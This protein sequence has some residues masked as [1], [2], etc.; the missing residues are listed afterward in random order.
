M[1]PREKALASHSLTCGSATFSL[2]PPAYC[3]LANY[4]ITSQKWVFGDPSS[5]S[6]DTSYVTG[7]THVYNK[8]GSFVVKL[9]T[10]YPCFV[11]TTLETVI[12]SGLPQVTITGKT[13][14]CLG[15]QVTLAAAGANSYSWNTGQQTG[16]VL[17]TPGANTVYVVTGFDANGCQSHQ[18]YSVA[19][20]EC[21]GL[22]DSNKP[23]EWEIYPNPG[24]GKFKVVG[25]N[26]SNIGVFT[27]Q[28]LQILDFQAGEGPESLDISNHPDG[29]YL[30][31]LTGRTKVKILVKQSQ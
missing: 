1:S 19:V 31:R 23:D 22:N 2:T 15:E 14:I 5:G 12:V 28:G 17:Q 16:T 7:P 3:P 9:I 30:V 21:L 13:K 10:Y 11:D 8:N 18:Q 24:N 6:A 4:S 20:D 26:N 25:A 29:I 27:I